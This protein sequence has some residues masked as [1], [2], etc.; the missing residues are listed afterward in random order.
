[1]SL[2][3]LFSRKKPAPEKQ[4]AQYMQDDGEYHSRAEEETQAARNPSKRV[5]ARKNNSTS[6]DPALPEKKRARRRLIGA[7][8]MVLAA[9]IGL[10]MVFDSEPKPT[11]HKIK[12]DIPSKDSPSTSGA[13]A[14]MSV[15]LSNKSA[16]PVLPPA[17]P[18]PDASIDVAEEFISASAVSSGAS[19]T[20]AKVVT[21]TK[22]TPPVTKTEIKKENK[23]N[24]E[25][26]DVNTSKDEAARALALLEGKAP[27]DTSAKTDTPNAK[28][29]PNAGSFT[30]QVAA[31]SN[32]TKIVELQNKLKAASIQSSTQKIVTTSGEVSRIRVGPFTT[33]AEAEKMRVKLEKLG[34][35]GKV[36]PY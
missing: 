18:A 3:S 33:K 34:L 14:S 9:V 19:V 7:V 4:D 20:A 1:M 2:D 10:P 8:A 28:L 36:I 15:E 27:S 25:A 16:R 22:L 29:V 17:L 13:T 30:V 12:L 26:K 21:P 35:G 11:N 5:S 31:L 6:P 23:E 32:P 24:K